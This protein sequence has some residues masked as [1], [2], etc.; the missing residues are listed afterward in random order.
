MIEEIFKF[1]DQNVVSYSRKKEDFIKINPTTGSA[2]NLNKNGQ[3]LFEVNNQAS[4]MYF[5]NSFLVCDFEISK[6]DGTELPKEDN[7]TLEHNFFPRLF[8]QLRLQ[9]GTTTIEEI[10]NPGEA[11]TLIKY[12]TT[13]NSFNKNEGELYG[14]IPDHKKRMGI[15]NSKNKFQ[16]QW[17]LHPLL[18]FTDFNKIIW[19]L[20]V[21]LSLNRNL[22]DENIFYTTTAGKEAKINIINL[23]WWIPQITPSLDVEAQVS[24][25]LNSNKSIPFVILKRTLIYTTIEA[26]KYNWKIANI[27][28]S[29]RYIIAGFKLDK[30]DFDKDNNRFIS[31][32]GN[33]EI[34]SLRI[35]LNQIYYPIDKMEFSGINNSMSHPYRNYCEMCKTFGVEPPLDYIT[36]KKDYSIFCF[37]V[38]SQ[39]EDLKKNGI[40]ITLELE[41]SNNF[42]LKAFCLLLEDA[43]YQIVTHD[44]NMIRIE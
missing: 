36:F 2:N 1:D 4:Y 42:D 28:N 27:S 16:I 41:K 3:I 6:T 9:I 44:G 21:Y 24:K 40:D 10:Q 33:N 38:S 32:D 34:K 5:P 13:S 8:N 22:D 29:P 12:I 26:Q 39:Q 43:R 35:A 14:W 17:N 15:Y 20:K 18:G 23:T 30:S 37:D 11:D 25:R 19:G 31:Y 7:I